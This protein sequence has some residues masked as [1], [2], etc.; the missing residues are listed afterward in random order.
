MPYDFDQTHENILKSA[1]LQFKEKGFRDASIR[2]ICSDAGVT[3]GAFYAHFESKEDLFAGIVEPCIEELTRLYA[4][5]EER[6]LDI[7]CSE[8]VVNAFRGAYISIKGFIEYVCDNREEFLLILESSA[9][10]KYEDFVQTLTEYEAESMRSFLE[11]SAEYISS[12]ENVS[13]NIIRMGASFLISTVFD[14]LKR[15]MSVDEIVHE[16]KLVSDYCAAGYKYI[17]GLG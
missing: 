11:A 7:T 8:D 14:G 13:D 1:R 5:E 6:F 9:G 16:T 12:K 10:T 4:D 2:K 15:E 3:N 17:L